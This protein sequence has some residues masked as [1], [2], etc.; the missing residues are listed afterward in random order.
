MR[1]AILG[2][3]LALGGC[4]LVSGEL[5]EESPPLHD[6]EEP[7]ALYEEPDDEA[8][9]RALPPGAFTG[10]YVED[11]RDSLEALLGE[12]QGVVVARVVE[13][14][15]AAVAGLEAGDLIVEARIADGPPRALASP[16]EWRALELQCEPG[17][18]IA[19]VAD[20]AGLPLRAAIA[21]VPRVEP[22]AR[23]TVERLREEDRVGVVVRTAT[24][25]EA[26]AAGLG[27]GGGAVVVG[28]SATS[29]WR[30]AGL[31]FGDLIRAID[32][33]RVVAPE[34]VLDAIRS[35]A[36]EV[37]IEFLRDGRVH[38]H[39]AALSRRE[40]DVREVYVPLLFHYERERDRTSTSV[41]LGLFKHESTQAASRT[42]LLWL[43]RFGSGDA[44]RLEEV[45]E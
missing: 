35:G 1:A 21:T 22:A 18:T 42:R 39:R 41:L 7:R 29:P 28:L 33:R 16:S 34:V 20:R 30:A 23:A 10:A 5:P 13:N 17:R 25:V 32:D 6:L 43:I 40:R 36:D 31:R 27:P 11:A 15:P 26:R 3:A 4:G 45:D 8:Q 37:E 38:R 9:R 12:P 2:S 24:E 19:V 44:D 14:S